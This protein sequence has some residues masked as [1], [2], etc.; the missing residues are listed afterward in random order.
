MTREYR[1]VRRVVTGNDGEGRSRVLYDN[2][3]PNVH[4][5]PRSPG[6]FFFGLLTL[7]ERAAYRRFR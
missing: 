6:I 1:P 7:L 4:P 5:R 3:A 2:D